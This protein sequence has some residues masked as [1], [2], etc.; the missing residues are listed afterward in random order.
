MRAA[1]LIIAI[2]AVIVALCGCGRREIPPIAPAQLSEQALFTSGMGGYHTYRIP[3]LLVTLDGTAL[4]F[5]EGRRD[6]RRDHGDIDVL[7]RRST[8]GGRSWSPPRTVADMGPDTIGNPTAVQDRD[9]GTVWLLLCWN[10]ADD[11]EEDVVRGE[12]GDTRRV[13]AIT[14]DDDGETWTEPREITDQVKAPDMRWYGTGPGVGIQLRHGLHAGR[15]VIPGD[16]SYPQPGGKLD[17]IEAAFGGHVFFSDDHG[18]T[19]SLGGTVRPNQGEAQ[20]VERVDPPGGI[21]A[22][23]RAFTGRNRRTQAVS[24]DGGAS[25]GPPRD[26]GAL[27]EPVC[28]ASILRYAWPQEPS[29]DLILFSNPASVRREDLAVRVSRD[30]GH[31]WAA[32]RLVHS[33]PAAYS[34]LARLPDDRVACLYEGGVG[35]PYEQI[36]LAVFP[37]AALDADR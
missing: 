23:L 7:L 37:L 8:D 34:C 22:N 3:S 20:V 11:R 12:A 1:R 29:G 24:E 13:F 17:G 4:A 33:G 10:L 16:H 31:T 30:G 15:L 21:L 2:G 14:S 19:W 9:T 28:Q 36:V 27:V 32:A 6:G 26:A 18:E 5:V 25:F 35:S